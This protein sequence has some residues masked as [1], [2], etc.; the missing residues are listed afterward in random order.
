MNNANT[1]IPNNEI[2][3]RSSLLLSA[4]IGIIFVFSVFSP[5]FMLGDNLYWETV[6]SDRASHLTGYL[7]FL[8][9]E[10]RWPLFHIPALSIPEGASLIFA[11]S[12]PLVS[13]FLKLI[14]KF[15]FSHAFNF[16]G[17]WISLCYI[18]NGIAMVLVLYT[19]NIRGAAPVVFAT[20]L[21]L[22]TPVLLH[23]WNHAALHG[24]FLIILGL[25]CYTAIKVSEHPKKLVFY[26]VLLI[27]VSLLTHVYIM[28]MVFA[29]FIATLTRAAFCLQA[30]TRKWVIAA[31]TLTLILLF[32][33][34][35][36]LGYIEPGKGIAASYGYGYYSMNLYS[37]FSSTGSG[38]TSS[39]WELLEQTFQKKY[40]WPFFLYGS[41]PD[42]T[43]GQYSEGYAY[44]GAGIIFLLLMISPQIIIN[45]KNIFKHHWP[46]LLV[47]LLTTLYALSNY[48]YAGTTLV[49]QVS[50][51]VFLENIF[52]QF[53]ASGRFFW[54]TIYALSIFL[55]T[56]AFR[57]Y[58]AKKSLA[59]LVIVV[60]LQAIDTAPIRQ[61]LTLSSK[62]PSFFRLDKVQWKKYLY[63]KESMYIIPSYSCGD[64]KLKNIKIQLQLIAARAGTI[65]VN[66]AY[67]ARS[68][69]QCD[70]EKELLLS[71]KENH[72]VFVF[73]E[74]G[75]EKPFV[76]NFVKR[77]QDS[78]SKF[79]VGV[80]CF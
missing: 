16:F 44:L 48:V 45:A 8:N 67:L 15:L 53:R 72:R 51:P 73:F 24:H 31:L 32:C 22:L 21:A 36:L 47:L 19:L 59:L 6:S 79:N 65:P 69:K 26:N 2:S 58:G 40:T 66:S 52:N 77:H 14:N 55:I 4:G 10:W 34:I 61:I 38:F 23:R 76:K 27:I 49:Y 56:Y 43:G 57:Y 29:I 7:Y 75:L 37:P 39:G 60:I 46:I 18:L 28:A 62:S 12:I 42:A 80:I 3:L 20:I 25:Y 13:L 78:C 9:D 11:D 35:L 50:L 30:L 1:A 63:G 74:D 41:S 33:L 5:E 54:I 71:H 70:L 64:E 68:F 17:L